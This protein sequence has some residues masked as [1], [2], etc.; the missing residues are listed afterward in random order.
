MPI[1]GLTEN[2]RLTRIGK[3]HLGIKAVNPK[4]V[5]YPK[6]VDYFVL[7][8]EHPQYNELVTAFGEQPKELRI[9]L[10][11]D[12]E[13]RF[14]S[15]Y[16][17]CY[18]KTRGLI[19]KGD[20]ET[21]MRVVD[22]Q[23]RALA[24]R[25]SKEVVMKEAVCQGKECPDYEDRK[26]K[27]L[28]NLQFFLPEITGL[29]IWQ[30][31][32]SSINSIRNINGAVSTIKEIND[33]R[34]KFIPLLLT[35][36]PGKGKDDKG[37]EKT[38]YVLNLR[39]LDSLIEAVKKSM[40]KPLELIAGMAGD[41][42]EIELPQPDDERPELVTKDWEG[43]AGEPATLAPTPITEELKNALF[44]QDSPS[45]K[46]VSVSEFEKAVADL[47]S[48]LDAVRW[49]EKTWRSWIKAQLKVESATGSLEEVLTR[50]TPEQ[51]DRFITHVNLMW[52]A[53]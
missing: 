12:D 5:E 23:T 14:A 25:D 10:P 38:I 41:I 16:Y 44:G 51:R 46:K 37:K 48:K 26:C 13:E 53:R 31:D 3:I 39:S 35:I 18:S 8:K 45:A 4:G 1:K 17:R 27:E 43:Q 15:Q 32:T 2:R 21:A 30:I 28:M 29:G 47:Q 20:G 42:T 22:T 49:T 34:V 19:C 6:A 36:E 11:S 50:C 7:P 24:D 52:N 9:M 33:G 40:Q